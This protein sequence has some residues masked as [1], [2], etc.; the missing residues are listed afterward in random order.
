MERY[1]EIIDPLSVNR[2][3]ADYG[4]QYRTGIYYMDEEQKKTAEKM[5]DNLERKLKKPLAVEIK[6]IFQ[7]CRAEEEHQDYLI[8]HPQG[9]CHLPLSCFKYNKGQKGEE[10]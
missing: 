8:K 2:Q 4:Q 1:F 7:Y 6:P 9:Y 5:A 10:E 3:G